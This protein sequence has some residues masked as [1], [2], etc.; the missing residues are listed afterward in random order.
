MGRHG[1]YGRRNLRDMVMSLPV[2][3]AGVR[4]MGRK[5]QEQ[6]GQNTPHQQGAPGERRPERRVHRDRR[7]EKPPEEKHEGGEVSVE[8]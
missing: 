5:Q 8:K 3:V 1:T 7:F 4:R 2:Y 6:Q